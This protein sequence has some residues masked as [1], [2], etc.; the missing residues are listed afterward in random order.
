M[1]VLLIIN[2]VM[3]SFNQIVG[4]KLQTIYVANFK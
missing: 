3:F 1:H 2:L 4:I